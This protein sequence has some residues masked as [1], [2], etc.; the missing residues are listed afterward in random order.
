MKNL[1]KIDKISIEYI[2][3]TIGNTLPNIKNDILYE[4]LVETSIVLN[5]LL[6]GRTK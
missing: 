3:K 2:L 6:K 4:Y 5:D 1:S